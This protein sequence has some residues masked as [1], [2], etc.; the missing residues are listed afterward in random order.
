MTNE[1]AVNCQATVVEKQVVQPAIS[2]ESELAAEEEA[3]VEVQVR[4]N[5]KK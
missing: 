5:E 3:K 2:S 4:N 1:Q